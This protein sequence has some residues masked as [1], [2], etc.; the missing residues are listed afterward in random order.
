MEVEFKRYMYVYG[1]SD[2]GTRFQFRF[3]SGTHGLNEE[4]GWHRGRNG[5]TECILW[6]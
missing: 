5:M 2:A 4:L 3:R 6:R 1:V